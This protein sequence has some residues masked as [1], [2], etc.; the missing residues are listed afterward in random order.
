[1]YNS[2]KRNGG[3]VTFL[4]FRDVLWFMVPCS[5]VSFISVATRDVAYHHV[6]SPGELN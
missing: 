3:V 4:L 1:M 2:N 5:V 6:L